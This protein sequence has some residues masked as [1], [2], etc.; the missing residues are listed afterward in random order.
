M[1]A[2]FH[3]IFKKAKMKHLF[4]VKRRF[5]DVG[6]TTGFIVDFSEPLVLFHT[7]D[8]DSFRLNGYTMIRKEDLTKYRVFSKAE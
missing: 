3:S 6:S 7:L 4:E 5:K 2:S 8:T 1:G